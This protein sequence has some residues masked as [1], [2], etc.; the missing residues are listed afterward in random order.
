MTILEVIEPDSE[1]LPRLDNLT[2]SEKY[3]VACVQA[4]LCFNRLG[5]LTTAQRRIYFPPS[6]EEL[7][8]LLSLQSPGSLYSSCNLD[9]WNSVSE[10]G[11]YLSTLR[12]SWATEVYFK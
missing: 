2:K 6:V 3:F 9:K 7:P 12:V 10:L 11:V 8:S 5:R 1:N 4:M